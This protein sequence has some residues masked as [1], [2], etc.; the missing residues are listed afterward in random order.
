VT[1]VGWRTH[2]VTRLRSPSSCR[3][4]RWARCVCVSIRLAPLGRRRDHQRSLYI[5]DVISTRVRLESW[6]VALRAAQCTAA[7]DPRTDVHTGMQA[8]EAA[9]EGAE[10]AAV[11]VTYARSDLTGVARLNAVT[12]RYRSQSFGGTS[13][14]GPTSIF[15]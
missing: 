6:Q 3:E 2:H 13:C 7:R 15:S 8:A 5:V 10:A 12:A 4:L 1:T 9:A 14:N 11:R